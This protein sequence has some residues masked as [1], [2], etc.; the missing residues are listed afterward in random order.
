MSVSIE[1]ECIPAMIVA[2]W[3]GDG[4]PEINEYLEIF[5][6]ELDNLLTNGIFVNGHKIEI[7]F[8]RVLSDTPARCLLKGRIRKKLIRI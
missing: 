1:F 7:K 3:Y 2:I 5:I 4:K 8:G 6:E